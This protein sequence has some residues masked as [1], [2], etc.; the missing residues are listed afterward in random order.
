MRINV[1]IPSRGRPRQLAAALTSLDMTKSGEHEVWF[2][3][4]CDDDDIGTKIFLAKAQQ[5]MRLRVRIGPRPDSLGSIATD[6]ARQWPADA[7][8]VFGDDM[9]CLTLDWDTAIAEAVEKIPHGVFWWKD[10][11]GVQTLIPVVTEK[12]RAAAGRVFTDLFPFWYDD[13]WL[14]EL[15]VMATDSDPIFLDIN[16]LDRPQA[17]QRMRDLRWWNEFYHSMRGERVKEA[18]DI[19]KALGLPEPQL[20]EYTKLFLDKHSLQDDEE[21]ADIMRRNKAE[22]TPPDEAYNRTK[23]RAV[24]MLRKAA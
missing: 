24:Q 3:V 10:G 15:W 5:E 4:A 14:Y 7:Y 2:C 16:A 1:L 21:I 6:L 19:A 12:W 18:R 13:V 11:R 17:T 22:S 23:E 9:L 8:A 20:G